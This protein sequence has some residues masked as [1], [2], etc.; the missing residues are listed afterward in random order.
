VAV[1]WL[2]VW[3]GGCE[4]GGLILIFP[5]F[6]SVLNS[7]QPPGAVATTDS[8]ATRCDTGAHVTD[9]LVVA[10]SSVGLVFLGGDVPW[11][12]GWYGVCGGDGDL[13]AEAAWRK[14]ADG[15]AV[16]VVIV[17][18]WCVHLVSNLCVMTCA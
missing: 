13:H 17:P 18:V 10:L 5:W 11:R 14:W 8:F 9:W 2:S 15:G 6:H 3:W 16:G 4:A 12:N 7:G 1:L